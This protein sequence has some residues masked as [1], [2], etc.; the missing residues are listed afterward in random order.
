[1]VA[2]TLDP[3]GRQLRGISKLLPHALD[4][5]VVVRVLDCGVCRTDLRIIDGDLPLRR[6][7][8][9]LGH[10]VVGQVM[11]CSP[12]TTR[13]AIGQRIGIP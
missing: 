11:A 7:G 3:S 2:M 10:E 5:D 6:G 13:F 9:V 8:L 12:Q 1:M 4:H